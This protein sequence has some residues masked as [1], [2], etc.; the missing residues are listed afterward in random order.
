[1]N[2]KITNEKGMDFT[3]W[4]D[5]TK[6]NDC[7]QMIRF[8]ELPIKCKCGYFVKIAAIDINDMEEKFTNTIYLS[9]AIQP[10]GK[11]L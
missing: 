8:T 7:G 10:R 3:T 2:G 1:M 9:P 5:K 6:C 11:L 4:E